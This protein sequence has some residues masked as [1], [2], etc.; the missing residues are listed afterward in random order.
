MIVKILFFFTTVLS[1]SSFAFGTNCPDFSGTFVEESSSEVLAV[2]QWG[3]TTTTVTYRNHLCSTYTNQLIFDGV[4]YL[5]PGTTT[6]WQSH[7]L[8]KDTIVGQH[9]WTELGRT[10][11]ALSKTY[12]DSSHN[13][14]LEYSNLDES[15]NTVGTTVRKFTTAMGDDAP[16]IH[17]CSRK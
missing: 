16:E 4:K 1:V 8:I 12:L 6:S 11:K 5:V 13:L 7:V 14:I 15:G 9:E 2:Q 3:C 17:T 10:Y